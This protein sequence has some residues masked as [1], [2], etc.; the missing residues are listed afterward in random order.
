MYYSL[1]NL[2]MI[3]YVLFPQASQPGMN[4]DISELVNCY[5]SMIIGSDSLIFV[6]VNELIK[7][8]YYYLEAE[9]LII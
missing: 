3:S 2:K 5:S 1:L 9:G 6:E 4:F 8:F 7:Y